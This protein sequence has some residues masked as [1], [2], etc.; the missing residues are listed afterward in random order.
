MSESV[1]EKLWKHLPGDK[2]VLI[3]FIVEKDA[4]KKKDR[5]FVGQEVTPAFKIK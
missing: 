1:I 3:N 4:C 2:N 5:R